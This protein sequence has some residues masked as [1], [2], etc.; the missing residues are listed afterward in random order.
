MGG[1]IGKS[2]RV[3]P[4]AI[5]GDEGRRPAA[6][7]I[8]RRLRIRMPVMEFEELMKGA[9][10]AEIGRVIVAECL[11]GRWPA[12]DGGVAVSSLEIISEEMT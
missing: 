5:D 1:C 3:A 12:T 11:R 2:M 7:R 8:V 6:S 4:S 9:D 10:G